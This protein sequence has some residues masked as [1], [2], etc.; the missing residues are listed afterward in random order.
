MIKLKHFR[1][2]AIIA[3]VMLR[4]RYYEEESFIN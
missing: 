3:N 4:G 2:I 1:H